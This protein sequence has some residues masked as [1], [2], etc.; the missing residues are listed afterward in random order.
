MVGFSQ[1]KQPHWIRIVTSNRQSDERQDKKAGDT[2]Y[3]YIYMGCA[4]K[5]GN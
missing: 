3:T 1:E 4:G 5:K 2:T